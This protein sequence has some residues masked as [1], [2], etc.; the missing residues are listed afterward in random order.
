[1]SSNT[2][3]EQTAAI[4]NVKFIC[5]ILVPSSASFSSENSQVRIIPTGDLSLY[6]FKIKLFWPFHLSRS[7]YARSVSER[8]TTPLEENVAV[9]E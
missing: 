2:S 8:R 3:N 9:I 7:T 1:M 4:V 6:E 5:G